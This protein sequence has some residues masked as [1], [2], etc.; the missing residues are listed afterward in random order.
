V[1]SYCAYSKTGFTP[2]TYTVT[3]SF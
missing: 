1:P 2:M 3:R